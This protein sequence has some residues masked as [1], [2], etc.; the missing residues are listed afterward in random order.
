VTGFIAL[1]LQHQELD[2]AALGRAVWGPG[3]AS[4]PTCLSHELVSHL[5]RS[6]LTG[7]HCRYQPAEPLT[8]NLY[9]SDKR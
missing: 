6:I 2:R 4:R 9:A 7:A 3:S 8:W 1:S 5:D